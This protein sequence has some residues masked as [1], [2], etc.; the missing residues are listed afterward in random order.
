MTE[1]I[2]GIAVY[3]VTEAGAPLGSSA[4]A[5]D[6]IGEMYGQGADVIFIPARRLDPEFF[7]LGSG[8]AGEFMQKLQNYGYRIAIVGDIEVFLKRSEPL[9]A[10]VFE[11]NRR[12]QHLFVRDEPQLREMLRSM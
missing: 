6:L 2:N 9:R 1:T 3:L 4:S 8:V 10:F 12:G 5:S 11:S 7:R